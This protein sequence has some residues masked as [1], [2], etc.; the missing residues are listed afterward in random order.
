MKNKNIRY[1]AVLLILGLVGYLVYSAFK[2]EV[3]KKE[4]KKNI[5]PSLP[6]DVVV[7]SPKEIMDRFNT[8]STL[9]PSEEVDLSFETSGML[10]KLDFIEGTRV[11]RGVLLAKIRDTKLQ[12]QLQKLEAQLKL[13]LSKEYRQKAL[14]EQDAIS[15]ETYDQAFT[16]VETTQADIDLVKAQIME[17]ELRAPFDGVLGLRNV[18]EGAYVTPSTYITKLSKTSPLKLEFSIPEQYASIVKKGTPIVFT[19]TGDTT[20]YSAAVYATDSRIDMETRTLLVRAL[21]ANKN[22]EIAAGRF[23]KVGLELDRIKNG[24]AVPS[25]AVIPEMGRQTVYIVKKGKANQV[26]IIPGM[27]TESYVQVMGGLEFGDTVI[28]TGIL[29]LRQ[30]LDVKVQNVR[31]VE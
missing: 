28:T 20:T 6:V 30:G 1:I 26:T 31:S 17:T 29:Q 19:I 27:R 4:E 18:S 8:N 23:A 3:R 15:Q 11:S 14:L 10:V 16:Q 25:E 9:L 22:Q 7:I 12:A 13:N 5:R 21:Y 24:M 2:P